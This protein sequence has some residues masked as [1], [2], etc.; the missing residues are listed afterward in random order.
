MTERQLFLGCH[1][2]TIIVEDVFCLISTHQGPRMI[3]L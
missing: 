1:Q 3:A 2:M